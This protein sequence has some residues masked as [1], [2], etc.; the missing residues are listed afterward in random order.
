MRTFVA[1]DLAPYPKVLAY[2]HRIGKREGYRRAMRK[3][4]P[5]MKP[6]LT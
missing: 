1:V 3:G 6:L 5:E 2:L 4:D